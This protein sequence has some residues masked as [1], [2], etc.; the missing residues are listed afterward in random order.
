MFCRPFSFTILLLYPTNV[1]V[2]A[3]DV[4]GILRPLY[5]MSPGQ[6]GPVSTTI[7]FL[8]RIYKRLRSPGIDFKESIPPAY[9]AW[10]AGTTNRVI[11]LARQ[12]A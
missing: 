3:K 10:R 6:C 11:V 8:S 5:D 4:T 9:V 7:P 1:N 12:A 2:S